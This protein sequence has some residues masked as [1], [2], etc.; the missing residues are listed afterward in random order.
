MNTIHALNVLLALMNTAM[1][2]MASATQ[3][4]A[5]IKAAQD[6]GRTTLTADEMLVIKG[7]DDAAR[8]VLT[9]AIEQATP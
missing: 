6:D 2:A 1:T 4:S 3:V 5:I 8:K 7:I 9:D